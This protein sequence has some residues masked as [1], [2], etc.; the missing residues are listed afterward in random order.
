MSKSKEELRE[1]L[2]LQLLEFVLQGGQVKTV[3][4]KKNP[5]QRKVTA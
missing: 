2:R 4:G 5:V 1:E 3:K